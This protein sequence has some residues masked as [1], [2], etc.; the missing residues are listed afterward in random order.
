ME[1]VNQPAGRNQDISRR[2]LRLTIKSSDKGL[3]LIAVEHLPMITPPQPGERPE[4]GRHSGHWFEL[5]D[6]ENRVLAHR[7]IDD[8]LLNSVEV[9]SPDGKIQ[10][11]FGEQRDTTFEVLLPDVDGARFAVF[12]G[13]P[14]AP[15]KAPAAQADA[16]RAQSGEIARFDL[17]Q[18]R[19]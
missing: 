7:L 13:D 5:R 6:A 15:T 8:T 3:E 17:S 11:V 1:Q 9:H 4:A 16:R 19:K 18:V 10:R 2:T 14:I 12:V